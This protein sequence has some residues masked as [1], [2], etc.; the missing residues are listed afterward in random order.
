MTTLI[1]SAVFGLLLLV[2]QLANAA[3]PPCM[4]GKEQLSIDNEQVLDWKSNTANQ[5]LGR[6]RVQGPITKL[7][8]DR[9]NHAH[10]VIKLGP[11]PGD[12][13]EVVYNYNFGK[14]PRLQPG[15]QVEAC[16][17]YITSTAQSGN[18]APSPDG[19]IIHWVHKNPKG[20]GHESGYV[21]IDNVLYGWKV[22]ERFFS[23]GFGFLEAGF[24]IE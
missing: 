12:T 22:G 14:L 18:Y 21:V 24:S 15:M 3:L 20:R 2:T 8:P 13:L 1:R 9:N 4:D 23:E 16:G 6:A 5:F 10:F 7:Y 17:D 19:A 11:K